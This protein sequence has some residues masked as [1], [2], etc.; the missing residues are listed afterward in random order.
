MSARTTT[1][2]I[3]KIQQRD[4]KIRRAVDAFHLKIGSDF[5]YLQECEVQRFIEQQ[6]NKIDEL[7]TRLN[8]VR[9]TERNRTRSNAI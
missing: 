7:E 6:Q 8:P 3:L 4:M 5:S 2:E 1:E 9:S